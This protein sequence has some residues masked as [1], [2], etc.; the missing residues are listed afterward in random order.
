VTT[1]LIARVD[2]LPETL[3]DRERIF[4]SQ[5]GSSANSRHRIPCKRRA[6]IARQTAVVHA[7]G[8]PRELAKLI[9]ERTVLGSPWLG[10]ESDRAEM[11]AEL[12]KSELL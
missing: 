1:T 12:A 10:Y 9:D 3:L 8:L 7:A 11:L 5:N 2:G 6:R 4:P